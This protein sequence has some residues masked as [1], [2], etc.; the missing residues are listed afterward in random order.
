VTRTLQGPAE[1]GTLRVSSSPAPL[2]IHRVEIHPQISEVDPSLWDS[3]LGPDD[4]QATH[5]FISACEESGVE[6]AAYRHI[7]VSSRGRLEGV[8]TLSRMTVSLELLAPRSVRGA[9]SVARRVRPR[10]MRIPVVFC[11]LPVSF[12][13]SCIRF[14]PSSERGRV[15]GAV[16]RAMAEFAREEGASLLCLKEFT[17]G[18][19]RDLDSLRSDGYIRARSLPGCS[20]RLRWNRFEEYLAALRAPYRRQLLADMR[21]RRDRGIRIRLVED[22]SKEIGSIYA[23]YEQVMDRAE[24]QLERLNLEFLKRLKRNLGPQ[25]RAL[26][27]EAEDRLLAAALLLYTPQTLTFLL[28][29]IDYEVNW[30]YRSYLNLVAAVVAE[31]I[32]VRAERLELGQTSYALKTRLGGTTDPRWIYL[33]ARSP[34]AHGVLGA[35]HSMLFPATRSPE[36]HVFREPDS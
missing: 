34:V 27:L 29:G 24:F 26:L 2:A 21:V 16:S 30:E 33:R 17:E 35:V 15:L 1:P 20:L 23:L 11:G 22:Y 25:S 8:A 14:H 4:L 31:G 5:R 10:F 36:R 3:I 13:Q 6:S 18:E 12:G 19:D 32:R 7:L 28:A 9:V